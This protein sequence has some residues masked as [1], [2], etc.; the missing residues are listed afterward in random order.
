MDTLKKISINP[1]LVFFLVVFSI[2]ITRSHT[3]NGA[4]MSMDSL[5]YLNAAQ[6]FTMGHGLSLSNHKIGENDY[7]AMTLWPPLYPLTLSALIPSLDLFNRSADLQIAWIN[8]F[9]LSITAVLFWFVCKKFIHA[10]IAFFVT[11]MLVFLPSMQVVYMY[12]W[13]EVVFI[14]LVLLA[15]YLQWMF[16]VSKEEHELKFLCATI[17]ALAVAF[18][19]RY[20]GLGF[21]GG[22]LVCI[23]FVRR[24]SFRHRLR[25]GALTV[26]IF[27]IV[28]VPLLARNYFLTSTLVGDRDKPVANLMEDFEL[29]GYFLKDEIFP[30]SAA[31]L[32]VVLAWLIFVFFSKKRSEEQIQENGAALRNSPSLLFSMLSFLWCLSYLIF[33]IVNRQLSI[34]D[35]DP[36]MIAPT[37]PF[38]ILGVSA[39]LS[40][41]AKLV[42]PI[43]V[44]LPVALLVGFLLFRSYGIHS[45]IVSSLKH[46]GEPGV[47]QNIQYKTVLNPQTR[48]LQELQKSIALP[49]GTVLLTDI[50]PASFVQ[51]FFPLASVKLLPGNLTDNT[52]RQVDLLQQP[53]LLVV[54]KR[55]SINLLNKVFGA[56]DSL[57]QLEDKE[58]LLSYFVLMK[59][60][61]GKTE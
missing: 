27:S 5:S 41:L 22:F 53:G 16:F 44:V 17:L 32:L 49:A 30:F 58:G 43:V 12:G 55:E 39:G 38:I 23:A 57:F 9:F 51:Y 59:L 52:L 37:V 21:L 54:T 3:P 33:L 36:R 35:L 8:A 1:F 25:W 46:N 60:P 14:P 26:A 42:K 40:Y 10:K 45:G 24:G 11:V 13:S 6:Q 47:I 31:Y 4:A 50:E 2:L 28:A 15:F 18:Y 48:P 20:A 56:S 34:M 19:T 61:V 29:L 7:K